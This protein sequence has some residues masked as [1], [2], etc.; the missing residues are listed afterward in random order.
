MSS[1]EQP[2]VFINYTDT[3][4][5]IT[6]Y[7]ISQIVTN[8]NILYGLNQPF[9]YAEVE[10]PK[11]Y[12]ND[13]GS[14]GYWDQFT[15]PYNEKPALVDGTTTIYI[16]A[17]GHGYNMVIEK[18]DS[19]DSTITLQ[20]YNTAY[21]MKTTK[22]SSIADI[23]YSSSTYSFAYNTNLTLSV[24]SSITVPTGRTLLSCVLDAASGLKVYFL[25]QRSETVVSV[26]QVFGSPKALFAF[27]AMTAGG[28][29]YQGVFCD[30]GYMYDYT[31]GGT[32]TDIQPSYTSAQIETIKSSS[33]LKTLPDD[34]IVARLRTDAYCWD[35]VQ[36]LGKMT[37]RH[38]FFYDYAYFVD[39]SSTSSSTGYDYF[40]NMYI[41]Y[42]ESYTTSRGTQETLDILQISENEDQGSTYVLG[43]QTVNSEN[44]S[45][46]CHVSDNTANVEGSR[47]YYAYPGVDEK[48][49]QTSAD[50]DFQT[51]L[52]AFNN[53]VNYYHPNDC[54]SFTISEVQASEISQNFPSASYKYSSYADLEDATGMTLGDI[55]CVYEHYTN[56]YYQYLFNDATQTNEWQYYD[57]P[58]YRDERFKPY[59]CIGTVTDHQNGITMSTVPLACTEISW[60][61]CLTVLW[62]GD[63]SFQDSQSQLSSL[64]T[65]SQ[66]SISSGTGDSEISDKYSAKIVVGNQALDELDDK[67]TNFT[68]LILEKNWDVDLYRLVG[69]KEG[70][71]QAYFNTEGEIMSGDDNVV[72][73]S[74]GIT[75]KNGAIVIEGK[76][77][78][79]YETID[80]VDYVDTSAYQIKSQTSPTAG[81]TVIDSAGLKTYDSGGNLKCYIDSNG[82]IRGINIYTDYVDIDSGGIKSYSST[83][84]TGSNLVCSMGTGGAFGGAFKT[85][86]HNGI[87]YVTLDDSGIGIKAIDDTIPRSTSALTFYNS[88]N[89]EM[90]SIFYQYSGMGVDLGGL[91]IYTEG[92]TSSRKSVGLNLHNT[93][94]P[95]AYSVYLYTGSSYLRYYYSDPTEG[96]IVGYYDPVILAAYDIG[97]KV[98][99]RTYR[100]G[101]AECGGYN[102]SST[103]TTTAVSF[104]IKFTSAYGAECTSIRDTSGAEGNDYAYGLSETGVTF[105]HESGD[106][107]YW[108]AWG[109]KAPKGIYE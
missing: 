58:A 17:Y 78:V 104:P 75:I 36:A 48:T 81:Q 5:T 45:S 1:I 88:D 101:W 74:S 66:S 9:C 37:N 43:T 85:G 98:W 73:N 65:T 38:P 10:V 12:F 16:Q 84:H 19:D 90:G 86:Y 94:K 33:H 42:G 34:T 82:N 95:S 70:V 50:R 28:Y 44:Y 55:A 96:N 8:V 91:K 39:L 25:I 46:T 87:P 100:S 20:C 89:I 7:D 40:T 64:M 2:T 109:I 103:A 107:F 57:N 11:L 26:E 23:S 72:I 62:F 30:T 31:V 69:Y 14:I 99:Y 106:G 47:I 71:V 49:L 92:K 24:D 3:N 83:S 67:R 18:H 80:N 79:Q 21:K 53:I 15:A 6:G 56:F 97:N 60:P 105:R 52:I 93:S 61:S 51:A 68:G 35:Q 77:Y 63:V 27:I 13:N 102:S 4:G 59:T 32:Y 29:N 108:R 76:N 22:I 41:D 54:V